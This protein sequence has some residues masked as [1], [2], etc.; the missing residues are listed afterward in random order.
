M[1]RN[2]LCFQEY[3]SSSNLE[4]KS[5]T[6]QHQTNPSNNNIS[7]LAIFSTYKILN[8]GF[9]DFPNSA[10]SAIFADILIKSDTMRV[11]NVHLQS[12]GIDA[13]MDVEVLDSE[14][15]NKLLNRLGTTFKAQQYQAEMVANHV[16]KSPYKV[17]ICGD[18]NNTI[19]S[20]VY[21]ILKGD[22]KDAFEASGSGFGKTFDYKFF[23]VRIDFILADQSFTIV[24]FKNYTI[25]YSDHFPLL[26]EFSLY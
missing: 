15:S 16:S 10:N 9:I 17:L 7:E 8:S 4:F 26:S 18:F 24:N 12:T 3:N 6:Y 23:P 14:Q 20:Y 19:Y 5:Y 2:I 25:P 1:N 22:L 21:R 11:Y 13:N